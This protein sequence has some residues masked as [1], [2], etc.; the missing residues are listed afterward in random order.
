MM[1]SPNSRN[2]ACTAWPGPGMPTAR[3]FACSDP[4][5]AAFGCARARVCAPL[6]GREAFVEVD[7][8]KALDLIAG[9]LRRVRERRGDEAIFGGSYGWSSAGRFHHAQSQ[10]HRLLNR[11]AAT[12]AASTATALAPSGC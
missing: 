4:Q 2:C 5:C 3:R 10:V 7:W 8:K 9:E 6:R 11:S 1:S 12:C